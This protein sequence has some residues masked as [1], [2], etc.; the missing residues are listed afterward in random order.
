MRQGAKL[1][2]QRL[3]VVGRL[4]AGVAHDFNNILQSISGELGLV[5]EEVGEGT[6]AHEFASL[7]QARG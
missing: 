7:A 1:R 5:L 2:A 3:E 6:T 4:A